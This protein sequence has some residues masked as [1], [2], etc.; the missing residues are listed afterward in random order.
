MRRRPDSMAVAQA[1]PSDC[2]WKN[3]AHPQRH[4]NEIPGEMKRRLFNFDWFSGSLAGDP[5]G[6]YF[7][8]IRNEGHKHDSYRSCADPSPEYIQDQDENV[9]CDGPAMVKID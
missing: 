7:R 4:L 5:E 9:L 2:I 6:G 8:M 3:N 1:F